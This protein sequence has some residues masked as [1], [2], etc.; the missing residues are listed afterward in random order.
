MSLTGSTRVPQGQRKFR[1]H[2]RYAGDAIAELPVERFTQGS[3]VSDGPHG[4]QFRFFR[5]GCENNEFT[6]AVFDARNG[7][8]RTQPGRDERECNSYL[9]FASKEWNSISQYVVRPFF[10]PQAAMAPRRMFETMRR[11]FFERA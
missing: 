4:V 2:S 3:I 10:E 11:K 1:E 8:G 6:A 9:E 7:A 5:K